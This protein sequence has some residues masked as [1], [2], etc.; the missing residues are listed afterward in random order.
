MTRSFSIMQRN[1]PGGS[2][3]RSSFRQDRT[4]ITPR[5][6]GISPAHRDQ[7]Q[8]CTLLHDGMPAPERSKWCIRRRDGSHASTRA[9]HPVRPLRGSLPEQSPDSGRILDPWTATELCSRSR[10]GLM[11]TGNYAWAAGTVPWPVREQDDRCPDVLWRKGFDGPAPPQ[12]G[13]GKCRCFIPRSAP[14]Q[15]MRRPLPERSHPRCP[16]PRGGAEDRGEWA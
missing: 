4:L 14:V 6:S 3:G 10:S 15:D 1:S 8:A 16:A 13:Q 7:M 5:I 2:G 11:W 9:L 12:G